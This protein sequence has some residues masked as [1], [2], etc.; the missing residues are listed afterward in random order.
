MSVIIFNSTHL[1]DDSGA[2]AKCDGEYESHLYKAG[3]AQWKSGILPQ[4]RLQP[5]NDS[6]TTLFTSDIRAIYE[7]SINKRQ[8]SGLR[9]IYKR[10]S[11]RA[12]WRRTRYTI[13]TTVL[14]NV[15]EEEKPSTTKQLLGV[16]AS[17]LPDLKRKDDSLEKS[18]KGDEEEHADPLEVCSAEEHDQTLP[19]TNTNQERR[20]PDEERIGAERWWS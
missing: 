16:V 11:S 2:P 20:D 10:S 14:Q 9:A 1:H 12:S 19:R 17:S 5:D 15:V 3:S 7:Q 4:T 8:T 6:T 13:Q 18:S